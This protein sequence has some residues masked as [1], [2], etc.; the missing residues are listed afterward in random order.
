M[1]FKDAL[2]CFGFICW[3]ICECF[4]FLRNIFGSVD[5]SGYYSS[6]TTR[7]CIFTPHITEVE[8]IIA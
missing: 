4:F 6:V 3:E 7:F 5:K 8:R 1:V 2:N